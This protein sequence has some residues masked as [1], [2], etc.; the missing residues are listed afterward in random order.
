MRN[1][2][3]TVIKDLDS[4]GTKDCWS[5]HPPWQEY[6]KETMLNEYDPWI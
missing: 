6:V 1:P 5:G 4:S 3:D 2:G